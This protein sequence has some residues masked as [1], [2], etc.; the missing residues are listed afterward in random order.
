MA[1]EDKNEQGYRQQWK[2][3][4][5]SGGLLTALALGS[6]STPVWAADAVPD[7][8]D[9]LAMQM[10]SGVTTGS[11]LLFSVEADSASPWLI[12]EI[13]PDTDNVKVN[14]TS[15]D[16]YEFFELCN[17]SNQTLNLDDFEIL[18]NKVD[19]WTPQER[20]I[21]VA[22]GETLTV[23]TVNR[24]IVT[25]KTV[26]DFNAYWSGKTDTDI[27]LTEGK[28]LAV[29]NC[30]G[31]HN[32]NER[33]LTIR[34]KVT[35]EALNTVQY[36][37]GNAK[38]VKLDNGV[39]FAPSGAVLETRLGYTTL[40]T[41]G[42][43]TEEQR[44]Q[45][46]YDFVTGTAAPTATAAT[47]QQ[48]GESWQVEVALPEAGILA[49]AVLYVK[50]DDASDYQA[51]PLQPA[52]D[53]SKLICEL[54]YGTAQKSFEWYAAF[55]Y[56]GASAEQ[57]STAQTVQVQQ[58]EVTAAEVPALLIT[59]LLPDS[60]NVGPEND[61]ADG[62]EFVELYN[63]SDKAINLK[64]YRLYY[65][66]NLAA[67]ANDV[68]WVSNLDVTVD[69]GN[70]VVFWIKN[71][72]NDGLTITDFNKFYKVNLVEGENLFELHN[73]GMANNDPRGLRITTNVHDELDYVTYN[74][75]GVKDPHG[76]KS[77]TYR[78]NGQSGKNEMV[79]NVSTPTPGA[80]PTEL[81]PTG[82]TLTQPQK[83]P[84]VT[85]NTPATF[86]NQQNLTFGITAQSEGATIKTVTLSYKD[87]TMTEYETYNLVREGS[88]DN[89]QMTLQPVDLTGKKSYTYYFTVS[90]GFKTVTTQ[91]KT[92]TSTAGEQSAVRFNLDN[93]VWVSGTQQVI[94]TGDKLII[95]GKDV[96]AA[97]T[98]AIEQ[99][100][101]FV[102]EASQTDTFFKNAV[103]VGNDVLGVFNDGTYGDWKT[104]AYDVD[105]KYLGKGQSLTID[106]HAGNKANP[107]V[108]DSEN[109]DDFVVRN[110]R[111]ILPDGTTLRAENYDGIYGNITDINNID[112]S[113]IKKGLTY[114]NSTE[115]KM[116][117]SA[118][119]IEILSAHFKPA[120]TSFNA[121]AY[122]LDTTKLP[123][124]TVTITGSKGNEQGQITLQVDNTAPQINSNVQEGQSCKG[125]LSLQASATDS[126][127]GVVSS[128]VMLDGKKITLPYLIQSAVMPA[129]T[130]TLTLKATDQCGNRA[131]KTITFTTPEEAPIITGAT[132]A[133]GSTMQQKPTFTA[134]VTDP[135]ED[136]TNVVFKLGECYTLG[137]AALTQSSGISDT[138][139]SSMDCF[140]EGSGGNGFPF[141]QF[142]LTVSDK[143]DAQDEL[144]IQWNGQT[145]NAKTFLYVW[146]VTTQSW[147]KLNSKWSTQADDSVLLEGTVSLAHHLSD[148]KVKVMVQNGE[149]YTPTQYA[150]GTAAGT[151][152]YPDVTT[153][154]AGD[155]PR[156]AYDF[157][158][159]VES[160]TQYYNEDTADN[161][162][163]VGK[164]QYQLDIH[165]W[166]LANRSRMNI[167]YLF[168]DG[169][170][171]DDETMTSQWKNADAAYKMLDDAKFPYG[172][173]AG[174]HDVGH[175]AGD[176]SNY[177]K[178][179]GA[180][181]YENNPWYGE[182][183][184]DNRAHYD[185]ITVDGIDFLMIYTGWGIGDEE[186]DW[187]NDVL[188][189]YPE[190]VAILNFH[191]YLLASSGLG[192]EPQRVHDE[193]VAQNP[194]V[195]MVL[196]G[197]YHNAQT[198]VD[199]FDDDGDGTA[200]RKVYQ[201][202]FD[203]QG[204]QEGGMGYIRLLH[205]D[206]DGQKMMVRTYSPVVDDYDAIGTPDIGTT[207]IAGEEE[208]T[209]PFADLGI[210]AKTKTLTTSN[211]QIN[212][213]RDEVLGD[214]GAVASGQTGSYLW[215]NASNGTYGWYAEATDAYGG[216]ARSN[217][218]Y[219]TL[220]NIKADTS[221]SGAS[222]SGGG[223]SGVYN[224]SV[225]VESDARAEVSLSKNNAVAGDKVVITV[226]PEQGQQVDNVTV[227]DANGRE[228]AV[229]KVS[230][231]QY[232]FIMPAG[233][234]KIAAVTT[235]ATYDKKIV[236]QLN[237]KAVTVNGSVIQ[238]D[239][240][241]IIVDGRTLVPIRVI[242]ETLGGK[243]DWNNKTHTVTLTI[244]GKQLQMT[245]GQTIA[246][247]DAAPIIHNSRTYVPIRYV[248]EALGAKVVWEEDAQQIVVTK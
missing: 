72:K 43:V 19:V 150:P 47:T 187:M 15:A 36:N 141:Q 172:L 63:N 115:I 126:G 129:G 186:I 2:K 238:N 60:T 116:G 223:F 96:T 163:I 176:Y 51:Y 212:L 37:D 165:D 144:Y 34:N 49:E 192:E 120:D 92:T 22:P 157:T 124:G 216:K 151:P 152:T 73:G 134:T 76:N 86:D 101:K 194:N 82:V 197:H 122:Q 97:A 121:I 5:I 48:A 103:A 214:A 98:P 42:T 45:N 10:T 200:E 56:A 50:A 23:W 89:F 52:E 240:A 59:E 70:C 224:Y 69:S 12:T 41:P 68:L 57:A 204:L 79:S 180:S 62:Y 24:D 184:K 127:S 81:K 112:S 168:H 235:A 182:S 206:K 6:M 104:Y 4:C 87:N 207:N 28:N 199:S 148:N 158:F 175:M 234:V 90:D 137:D 61:T 106:I 164:Y 189:Q 225:K 210:A 113:K 193:V 131:E 185:L 111:L 239:A 25:D 7:I 145:N 246:G 171:I 99:N 54:P 38:E 237:N 161:D 32:S 208:F 88:S 16:A 110:I 205:F 39:T 213:Y 159:A 143:A 71:G 33:Q 27:S 18:Y 136:E 132:P 109:N 173:L 107:L 202:L 31:F 190:R 209:V 221:G 128:S 114:D 118:T 174:N 195:R 53:G 11:A 179:F 142:E 178:Y 64:D 85:D 170:I 236:M 94:T 245:I 67:G 248:A 160:D 198:R 227:T 155:T 183:Y 241:P 153:S 218:Q 133:D 167:Q 8:T 108:H 140:T 65:N 123:D 244:N 44:P 169:D 26:A 211:L 17:V 117:D 66:N 154:N 84:V 247:F 102:F 139:G 201:M 125:S 215:K 222:S 191:E 130:H 162:M 228:I 91:E 74:T 217:V 14:G 242:T 77:I 9:M 13:V 196:S 177:S 149:G 35:K 230:D 20:G 1:N 135:T 78:Y 21:T 219:V 100:A 243:A 231:T 3:R 80:M 166:L 58:G 83:A 95:N 156:D 40:A 220:E 46:S 29:I 146:N 93:G 203:Y 138:S 55:R 226:T 232:S 229:T 30:G 181:R 119:T 75:S 105:P 233:A 147:D 188:A